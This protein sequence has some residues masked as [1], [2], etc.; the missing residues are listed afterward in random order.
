MYE[1]LM[2]KEKEGK[3]VMETRVQEMKKN[4]KQ[5]KEVLSKEKKARKNYVLKG[6]HA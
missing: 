3:E 2:S 1:L 6:L 4:I 5:L